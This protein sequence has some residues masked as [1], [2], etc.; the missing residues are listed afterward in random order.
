MSGRVPFMGERHDLVTYT[1][2]NPGAGNPLVWTVPANTIVQVIY[3]G[4]TL[5]TNAAVA[6][7]VPYVSILDPVGNEGPHS[8][9]GVVQPASMAWGH[10]WSIGIAPADWTADT[11]IVV[12]PLACCCQILTAGQVRVAVANMNAADA[13]TGAVIKVMEWIED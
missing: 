10:R 4:V 12:A 6:N 7:R 1:P 11:P 8:Y 9:P 13:I 3:V 5:T 2:G